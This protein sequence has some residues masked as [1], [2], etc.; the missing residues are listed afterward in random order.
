MLKSQKLL[1][2]LGTSGLL[3]AL[4]LP[5]VIQSQ[6]HQKNSHLA[7]QNV[8]QST[9][10]TQQALYVATNGNDSNKGT[11]NQPL[12]TI[13]H[14]ADM[15]KAGGTVYIRGGV[16]HEGVRP[17]NS[18][19][20]SKPI[21]FK[22][23][24]SESVTISGTDIITPGVNNIGKWQSYHTS[25]GQLIYEIHL[26]PNWNLGNANNQ[27]FVNTQMCFE[28][29]WP[30]VKDVGQGKKSDFAA[31]T[32]GS[33]DVNLGN[34]KY[35]GSFKNPKIQSYWKGAQIY[36][37]TGL[38]W[39]GKIGTVT[40]ASEGKVQFEFKTNPSGYGLEPESPK[41][42]NH[43]VLSGKLEA[44]TTPGEWFFDTKGQYGSANT[45]YLLPP[46]GESPS[47]QTVELKRRTLAVD[48]SD[49]SYITVKNIHFVAANIVMNANSE[50]NVLDSITSKYAV[51][52]PFTA[53]GSVYLD[54]RNNKL[55]NSEISNVASDGVVVKGDHELVANNRIHEVSY[56][57]RG[58]AGIQTDNTKG[59]QILHN[60]IYAIGS[61]GISFS[62][63][64]GGK[65]N[66]NEVYN[67]GTK[68][69][70]AAAINGYDSGD[71]HQLE[72]A[73]NW[74]HDS[75]GGTGIRTDTGG[76][77]N[78]ISNLTIHHNQVANSAG[79]FGIVIGSLSPKEANFGHS[80]IRVYNNTVD[81]DIYAWSPQPD[82]SAIG[83]QI[84][85][86]IALGKIF[87]DPSNGAT[88]QNNLD[89]SVN[90]KLVNSTKGD[91]HLQSSSP[92][93]N[94]GVIIPGINDK[95]PDGKPDIGAL[96]YGQPDLVVGA[97][98]TP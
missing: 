62:G 59:S 79:R 13:Q 28:A 16:Y 87:A 53:W 75:R 46:N 92:A 64:K 10:S 49:R 29:E 14:A 82:W 19:T 85:N 78:G 76:G 52:G 39:G 11:V 38:E 91:F 74:V 22:A 23:Y 94:A 15:V 54:G 6:Q 89:Y 3:I 90:V 37:L 68:I 34:G 95:V 33:L 17:K 47:N 8:A 9:S 5:L 70:D 66:Y 51:H 61:S 72:I 81:S 45:L 25:N 4:L 96:E 88:I 77:T 50:G 1:L 2:T 97:T 83:T 65:I 30:K 69:S 27:V 60:T 20:V 12:K 58:N 36:F 31:S 18:G 55:I 42:G 71:A 73:Y 40:V 86:N 98:P 48:L 80:G 7:L 57:F 21:T 41:T 35:L 67:T 44:L 32:A 26:T 63:M 24:K 84:K 56:D 43:F 93:I